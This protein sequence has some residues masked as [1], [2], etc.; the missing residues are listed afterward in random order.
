MKTNFIKRSLLALLFCSS[1]MV[2]AQPGEGSDNGGVD[3]DGTAD[4]SGTGAPI[5]G[6][7]T[8]LLAAGAIY[9]AKK[10]KDSRNK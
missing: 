8:L 7:L 2:F 10:V 6:G 4:T 1:V 3:D 9:G 5:D